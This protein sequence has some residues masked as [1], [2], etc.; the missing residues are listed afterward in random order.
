MRQVGSRHV[1]RVARV[2]AVHYERS[3]KSDQQE[4]STSAPLAGA[5]NRNDFFGRKFS[6]D[7]SF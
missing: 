6:V 7:T 2:K 1:G 5:G 3:L 4:Q